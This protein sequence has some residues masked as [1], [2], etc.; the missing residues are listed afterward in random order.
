[1]ATTL[2]TT[3]EITNWDE[4]PYEEFDDGSKLTRA[5]VTLSEGPDGL[6]PARSQSLMY[7]RPDGTAS[8][9]SLM[10]VTGRL[11]GRTGSFVLAGTGSYDSD[12][13]RVEITVVEGSGTG[14]LAGI[15]GT[16]VSVSTAKDYPHMPLKLVYDIA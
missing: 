13:A 1:M 11:D 8:M 10:H 9:V 6:G 7:Y 15:T 3:L 14:D 12:T 16:A 2:E 5:D 4:N